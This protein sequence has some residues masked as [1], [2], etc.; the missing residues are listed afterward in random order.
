MAIP[1]RTKIVATLGPASQDEDVLAEMIRAGMDVARL[2]LA[3]GSP[4]EHHAL[5]RT[6]RQVAQ[7]LDKA[8]AVMA[9]TPG[10]GIRTGTL[11]G[12]YVEFQ[13]G[14]EL[15]LTEESVEGGER[16]VYVDRKGFSQ[17]LKPGMRVL[18]DGGAIA[19]VVEEVRGNRV[20]CR[21]TN[22]GILGERKR[23]SVPE[24]E[25]PVVARDEEKIRFAKELDVDYLAV[26]FVQSAKDIEHA[27]AQLTDKDAKEIEIIAKI[28]TA[29]AIEHLD[30]LIEAADGLMVAR[31]DLG[32]ELPYQE[33][34][35][36]QKEIVTRCNHAGK[37]VII[38]TQ[39]LKSMTNAATPTRAEV[40]DVANA[41]LD[42]TDALMLSEE[43]AIGDYPVEAVRVMSTIAERAERDPG[44]YHR[45]RSAHSSVT[46]AIGGSACEIAERI[47]AAA[48]I[49][50]TTSG[51][52]AKRVAKFR[53]RVPIIAAT[54]SERVRAKLAL[55]WGVHPVKIDFFEDNELML[56]RSIETAAQV[57]ELPKGASV[58]LTA[59]VPFGV[60]GTTN[61]IKVEQV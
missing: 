22:T 2:N 45:Y 40:A 29:K 8:V 61:L 25:I 54:Y 60:P 47:Q 28:E 55:V 27:R 31:G 20:V 41:I 35:L 9:D 14:Q 37:P 4:E 24:V 16:Q 34:P 5:A 3:H 36:A 13:A 42:G 12:G 10:E 50:S 33:V 52:T 1:K 39:M 32:V 53:P 26:S 58:V 46:E 48:I 21:V 44:V 15:A 23:V 17:Y 11:K 6:V 59:G 49:P 7:R 56:Q 18:L 30:E 57:I 38:A 19:L 51:S 43:T